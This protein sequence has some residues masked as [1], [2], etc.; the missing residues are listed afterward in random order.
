MR[1]SITFK[2]R[3]HHAVTTNKIVFYFT[4]LG[5]SHRLITCYIGVFFFD[6]GHIRLLPVW[7]EA[8]TTGKNI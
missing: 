7:G 1:L 8:L 2:N 4:E 6:V 5:G 3:R